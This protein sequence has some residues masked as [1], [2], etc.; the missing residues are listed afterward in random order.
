MECL[1][2]SLLIVTIQV[3]LHGSFTY[4]TVIHNTVSFPFVLTIFG[5][6][7][8]AHLKNDILKY[9]F[10]L[11]KIDRNLF[12]KRIKTQNVLDDNWTTSTFVY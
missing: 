10:L 6:K 5:T 7:C 11:F 1:L 8:I 3:H 4:N 12:F 2:D 9:E